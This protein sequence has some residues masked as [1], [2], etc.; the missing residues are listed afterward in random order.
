MGLQVHM[1]MLEDLKRAAWGRTNPVSGQISSWEFRKTASV[2][3]SANADFG[4]RPFALRW[5]LDYIV[6]KAL[7]GSAD[8]KTCRRC[9]GRRRQEER[10]PSV[11][12]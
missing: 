6:S 12:S 11:G 2:T 7:G 1:T 4:N 5:E 10:K 9:T 8:P 3:S